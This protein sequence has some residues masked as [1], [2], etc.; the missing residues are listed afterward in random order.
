MARHKTNE[1]T[2]PYCIR[3]RDDELRE[4]SRRSREGGYNTIAGYIRDTLFP[5][6]F[7]ECLFLHDK[8]GLTE[9]KHSSDTR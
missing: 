6:G 1:N 4:L 3:L 2:S 7:T 8:A 5:E 9:P